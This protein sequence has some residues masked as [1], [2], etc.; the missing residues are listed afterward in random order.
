[1]KRAL[2]R[3][4]AVAGMIVLAANIVYKGYNEEGKGIWGIWEIVDFFG[5]M[6]GGW[7][8]WPEGMANPSGSTLYAGCEEPRGETISLEESGLHD[9]QAELIGSGTISELFD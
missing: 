2:V 8:I 4:T 3:L 1:M 7:H 6:S 9:S 5:R